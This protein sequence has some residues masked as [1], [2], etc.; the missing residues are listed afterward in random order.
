MWNKKQSHQ[1]QEPLDQ[2]VTEYSRVWRLDLYA[3]NFLPA[4]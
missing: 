2:S 3:V 1:P 4:G